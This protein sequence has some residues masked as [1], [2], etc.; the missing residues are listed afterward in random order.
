MKDKEKISDLK[1]EIGL[2]QED[3]IEMQEY[4]N[5]LENA[6]VDGDN[7]M[8]E[9]STYGNANHTYRDHSILDGNINFT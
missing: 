9:Y 2:M 1:G 8:V 4:I 7:D 3:M 5:E 6:V